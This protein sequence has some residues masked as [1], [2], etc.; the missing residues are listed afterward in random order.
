MKTTKRL[1]AVRGAVCCQNTVAS[2]TQRVPELYRKITEDNTIES[3]HIVSVQFSVNPELTALNPATALRIKGLAQDVPLFCSAE[4]YIDGYLKNII[5]I[6]ITYYGTSI[7]VPVY[8]YGAE[9]LR[10]DILQGS[11]RNKSTHE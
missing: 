8:L 2:I 10:P 11:L 1:Y 7:P 5:R 9:M 6:L 4:P 3:Q